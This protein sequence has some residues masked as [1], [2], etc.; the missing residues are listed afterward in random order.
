MK[1]LKYSVEFQEQAVRKTLTGDESIREIAEGLGISYWT[2]R[3][4]RKEY[5]K[6]QKSQPDE[7]RRRGNDAK[8]I[9]RL[10]EEIANLKMDNAILKK[11]AAML[12]RDD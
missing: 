5:I 12:S 7:P 2:L 1:K 6:N 11:Y 9:K 4:W 8:E 3:Q 10:K